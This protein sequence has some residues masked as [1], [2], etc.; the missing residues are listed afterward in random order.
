[1]KGTAPPTFVAQLPLSNV[2]LM[3]TDTLSKLKINVLE[4]V[5]Q[6]KKPNVSS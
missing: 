6:E 4:S 2:A 3:M 5:H 1:M